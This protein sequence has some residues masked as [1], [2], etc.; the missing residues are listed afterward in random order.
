MEHELKKGF[1]QLANN[2]ENGGLTVEQAKALIDIFSTALALSDTLNDYQDTMYQN[3][4][5]SHQIPTS[6]Y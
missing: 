6:L 1:S 3:K 4:K 2:I 5:N